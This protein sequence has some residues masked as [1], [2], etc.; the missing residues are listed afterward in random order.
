MKESQQT[1]NVG[2]GKYGVVAIR[3][4]WD[5]HDAETSVNIWHMTPRNTPEER[6][7]HLKIACA[8][9]QWQHYL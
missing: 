2:S 3:R 4:K 5:R 7:F 1:Y 6:R 8:E 9:I